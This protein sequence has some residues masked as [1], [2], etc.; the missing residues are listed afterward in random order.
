MS[1]GREVIPVPIEDEMRRSYLDYAMSTIIA[2]AL[3]DVRDGL[4]PVQ[5][6]ILYV[7]RML[8]LTPDSSYTKSAKVCGQTS[9]DFHPHGEAIIYPTL[10]RMAQ[11]FSMRYPLIQGQGNFGSVDG[12][13]PAAMRYT[14]V[15]LTPL[16]MEM[17]EDID[18]ETV[19]W[20]PNY[21]QTLEEPLLLPSKFPNLLCNGGTGIAVGMATNMP[22]HN[23]GEV[24]N[25]LLFRIE[26]PDCD[27]EALM[28]HLPGPD[29][30]TAGLVL[31]T[32]GIRNAY[33]T[34]RGSIVMQAKTQ[35]EPMDSGKSAIVVTE[36]PY[37]VNKAR[38]METIAELVKQRK[39][40]GITDLNDYSDRQGMRMVVELR[41]DANP[42][43]I[44]NFL[45]KH[46]ALRTTFGVITLALVDQVPRVMPLT[47][48]LDE[49]L[50]HRRTV[51]TRRTQYELHRAKQRGH[52]LEGLIK[53]VDILDELIALIRRSESA[54]AARR[55]MVLTYNFTVAQADAILA[56][57]LRS[58]AR[59][60]QQRVEDEYRDLLRKIASLED[61]LTDAVR[62]TSILKDELKEL[63]NKH[64]D[65]RRTRILTQE[66]TE[67]TD[68]DL[69]P[70]EES[71]V[72]ISRDGYIKRVGMDSYRSQKRGGKGIRASSTKAEDEIASI[73]QVSTHSYLLFFTDKGRVYRLK[74]YELPESSRQSKGTPI[75][76][77]IAIES[78]EQVTAWQTVRQLGGRGYLTMVTR[79]GEIKRTE[80]G[81]FQNLRANGLR[82]FDIEDGD[83]LGWVHHT[84]GR[85]E[86]VIITREG[87]SIRFKEDDVRGRGRAAGG[88]RAIRLGTDDVCVS[89]NVIDPESTMLVVAENGYGKRTAMHEYRIQTRGGKG[90]LTMKVTDKTGPVIGAAMVNRNDRVLLVTSM[91]KGIRIRMEE[92]RSIG[93]N[94]Q[95]VRLINLGDA[96]KVA[97]VA[98]LDLDPEKDDELR[99]LAEAAEP[100]VA[101]VSISDDSDDEE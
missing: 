47:S 73:F 70:E 63:R 96:D 2:R 24:V 30:P 98:R 6:R 40:D 44:L 66:A 89:C 10:V 57:Q 53:A 26:N 68:E 72:T 43:K 49:Y 100:D 58:L 1:I 88:V 67:I 92:V 77:Y 18:R 95:G 16:A 3:P 36:L 82:A 37:Q 9:G 91:G 99:E 94:T 85:D 101:V 20:Q 25:A 87:M 33:E 97:S 27:V 32:K 83:E 28:K 80:I 56:M 93:R 22:P 78:G 54:D 5:R 13:P 11:D 84:T 23:L 65:E 51:I 12:D 31:G 17:L 90:I 19:D 42:H 50:K 8:N 45:Y 14:E 52:I 71:L 34:G 4:K 64:A 62:L 61:I 59:L 48:V 29:F 55:E 39:V 75:I 15:R 41:R 60:E 7:M 35:I 46:T 81:F 21:L 74:A 76:N 69:I 86:I 38:L 79:K